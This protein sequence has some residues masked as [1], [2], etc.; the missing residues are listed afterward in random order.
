[1]EEA[2]TCGGGTT[3]SGLRSTG[4][5]S[6]REGF[7]LSCVFESA[8]GAGEAARRGR[9]RRA[10]RRRRPLRPKHASP[11]GVLFETAA[12]GREGAVFPPGCNSRPPV[13]GRAS[14][15][16]AAGVERAARAHEALVEA[17]RRS[18][19]PLRV[20]R[21]AAERWPKPDDYYTHSTIWWDP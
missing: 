4:I 3:S 7:A 8:S 18:R 5:P 15:T 19:T 12:M 11:L 20:S 10:D 16:R 2:T 14:T 13:T 9:D 6:D 1:M 21:F 17:G